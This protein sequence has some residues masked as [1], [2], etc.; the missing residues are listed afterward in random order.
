MK[1]EYIKIAIIP[2]DEKIV[3]MIQYGGFYHWNFKYPFRHFTEPRYLIATE[4]AI[5]ELT[6]PPR[7]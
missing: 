2:E 7:A 5:Y 4:K 1:R 3:S 6:V